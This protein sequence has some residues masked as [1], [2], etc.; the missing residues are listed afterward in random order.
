MAIRV[1]PR[2]SA[3]G[4][5]V[6]V[7]WRVRAAAYLPPTAA[8]QPGEYKLLVDPD[9]F[10]NTHAALADALATVFVLVELVKIARRHCP[11]AIED[12]CFRAIDVCNHAAGKRAEH[13]AK[14]AKT[15]KTSEIEALAKSRW[16]EEEHDANGSRLS[17]QGGALSQQILVPFVQAAQPPQTGPWTTLKCV[18]RKRGQRESE[19]RSHCAPSGIL[20]GTIHMTPRCHISPHTRRAAWLVK[21]TPMSFRFIRLFQTG[22]NAD[23][24][25]HLCCGAIELCNRAL[26]LFVIA[27]LLAQPRVLHS[28]A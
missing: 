20:V 16:R 10:C 13:Q 22:T 8:R 14:V 26:H 7:T 17:T 3:V 28:P 12:S 23:G 4:Y 11:E 21:P 19:S 9:G 5:G 18:Q 24:D 25:N 2:M 15:A 1:L 27:A 6:A